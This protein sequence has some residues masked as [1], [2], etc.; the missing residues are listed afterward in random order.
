VYYISGEKNWKKSS[1]V[2]DTGGTGY[3]ET[4]K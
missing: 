2:G 3:A 4:R 1:H